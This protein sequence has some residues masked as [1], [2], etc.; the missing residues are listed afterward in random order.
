[1]PEYPI[2][3]SKWFD[4]REF[5]DSSTWNLLGIKAQ[6]MISP[7]IVR[8]CDRLRELTGVPVTV[9]NWHFAKKSNVFKSSG[10][11]AVWDKTGG[12]LSQHRRGTAADVKVLGMAPIQVHR[13]I[14]AHEAEFKALGLTTLES[15]GY[16]RTWSH[17]DCRPVI[18]GV[19]PEIGFL[20]VEP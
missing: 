7:Q 2:H 3:G 6:W 15:L 8:V 12:Q 11:R 10:F 9:N 19:T 16:T 5:V 14:F 17:L 20:I 4:V 18:E 13:L 1:M